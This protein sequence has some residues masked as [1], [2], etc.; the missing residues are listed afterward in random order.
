MLSKQILLASQAAGSRDHAGAVMPASMN[1]LTNHGTPVV[2]R[3]FRP[4]DIDRP[5]DLSR[6][7]LSR[8]DTLDRSE[9]LVCSVVTGERSFLQ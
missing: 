4:R 7:G 5:L 1:R 2:F 8:R 9:P 6:V 3:A